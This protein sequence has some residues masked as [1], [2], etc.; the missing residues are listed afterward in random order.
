MLKTLCDRLKM[1]KKYREL[2]INFAKHYKTFFVS[3]QLE[4]IKLLKL[5]SAVSDKSSTCKFE[6]FLLCCKGISRDGQGDD[7]EALISGRYV[8][9]AIKIA[10]SVLIASPKRDGLQGREIGQEIQKL[11]LAKLTEF[12]KNFSGR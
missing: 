5:I 3:R 9:S 2:S 8:R 12:K 10:N 11:Q 4:P 7:N 1:P 6:N